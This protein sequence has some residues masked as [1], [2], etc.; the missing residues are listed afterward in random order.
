MVRR[1][2]RE[3]VRTSTLIGEEAEFKGTLKDK[4]SIRIDGK[5]EGEVETEGSV[6]VGKEAFIRANIKADSV[7]IEGKVIGNIDCNGRVE[8]FSSGSL[9]GKVRA[10]ELTVDGGALFNGECRMT[11]GEEVTEDFEKDALSEEE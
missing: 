3:K 11:S 8:L 7:S 9:E 1:K 4:E 2:K 10:S 6:V 5:F